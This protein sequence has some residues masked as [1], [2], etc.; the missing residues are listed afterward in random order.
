M[1]PSTLPVH[2]AIIPDGNNRWAKKNKVSVAKSYKAGFDALERVAE[3]A[4]ALGISYMTAYVLSMEN[5]NRRTGAWMKVFLAVASR[6]MKQFL[7]SPFLA[8][9]K[10]KILGDK[11]KIPEPLRTELENLCRLTEKNEGLTFCL[12]VAY[13]GRDEIL[14]AVNRLILKHGILQDVKSPKASP[15]WPITEEEFE[16]SLDT[17]GLP[18]PDLVIR[19]SGEQRLSGFLLWQLAY[20]EF[21]FLPELWPDVTPERFEEA[22]EEYT[23]RTRNFGQM[24]VA[25]AK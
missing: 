22:L 10:I 3:K 12:A 21:I 2:I 8:H 17:R 20:A 16:N 7:K 15:S 25:H 5:L 6:C 4:H 18:P 19:S 14:R 23:K 9:T 11:T 13:T 24:R 1:L